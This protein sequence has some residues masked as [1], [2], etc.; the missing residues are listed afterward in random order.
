MFLDSGHK[1]A[2]LSRCHLWIVARVSSS[3]LLSLY[4]G[5]IIRLFMQKQTIFTCMNTS[6]MPCHT[7]SSRN[8]IC[9]ICTILDLCVCTV[10]GYNA[11][12]SIHNSSFSSSKKT[13]TWQ[14]SINLLVGF[15]WA[16]TTAL[17]T[18]LLFYIKSI[19]LSTY[20]NSILSKN[21]A[22]ILGLIMSLLYFFENR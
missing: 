14:N 18:H 13:L 7:L 3:I 19:S 20:E 16:I 22:L 17:H 10:P 2:Y 5:R 21:F 1:K 6:F 11:E 9:F 15:I 8:C 4:F 12:E